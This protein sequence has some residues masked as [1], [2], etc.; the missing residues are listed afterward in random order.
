MHPTQAQRLLQSFLA[1]VREQFRHWQPLS[2]T[3]L[4]LMTIIIL[5]TP[6]PCR[7]ILLALFLDLH[8]DR[9]P[10]VH[11][12]STH[13]HSLVRPRPRTSARRPTATCTQSCQSPSPQGSH[14]RPVLAHGCSQHQTTSS[15]T[16]MLS[17][18]VPHP[19]RALV[20]HLLLDLRC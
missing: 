19:C 7:Q 12:A 11:R 1:Q 4:V 20:L 2:T 9:P 18:W 5:V 13:T 17:A 6:T 10:T 16:V 14:R 15:L 3:P 8:L